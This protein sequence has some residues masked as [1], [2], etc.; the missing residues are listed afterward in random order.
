VREAWDAIARA[1]ARRT[2]LV[3]PEPVWEEGPE[4]AVY[5][6]QMRLA[7]IQLASHSVEDITDILVGK[8]AHL[9][10]LAGTAQ[11]LHDLS[12]R[13][14]IYQQEMDRLKIPTVFI[15]GMLRL[16]LKER[17]SIQDIETI[18]ATII[19][20]WKPGILPDSLVERVRE[21]LSDWLCQTYSGEGQELTAVTLAPK[22]EGYLRGKL[23]DTAEGQFLDID[24]ELGSRFLDH[25]HEQLVPFQDEKRLLLLCSAGI[26]LALS[27]LIERGLP[28]LAVL[29]WNEVANDYDVHSVTTIDFK[30]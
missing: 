8:A 21:P 29:S 26:R 28:Q 3:L 11:I 14:P 19:D 2:G 15:H 30:F 16:L 7:K 12:Q 1:V 22:V 25:I 20:G 24:P 6:R 10:S 18:L 17:V 27:K 4:C 5:G 9:L 13:A 23:I